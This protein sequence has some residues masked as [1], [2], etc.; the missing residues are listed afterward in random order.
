MRRLLAAIRDFIRDF[1]RDVLEIDEE[2][3]T[4]ICDAL[5]RTAL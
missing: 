5:R 3:E 4:R 1:I 2:K